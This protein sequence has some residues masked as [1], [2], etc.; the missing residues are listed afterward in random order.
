[1]LAFV[2]K[3]WLGLGVL[4]L[5]CVGF[6][7]A[8]AT[9]NY[10][11]KQPV[12]H[13]H[14]AEAISQDNRVPEEIRRAAATVAEA[15]RTLEQARTSFKTLLN[16]FRQQDPKPGWLN[17]FGPY[18]RFK[19]FKQYKIVVKRMDLGKEIGGLQPAIEDL[20]EA[21]DRFDEALT[22]EESRNPQLIQDINLEVDEMMNRWRE[23]AD[24]ANRQS[25]LWQ[26]FI[27]SIRGIFEGEKNQ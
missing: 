18:R 4:F 14:S 20:T 7:V 1:M 27:S 24:T 16:S 23:R 11:T 2:H 21:L 13:G 22:V 26:R 8:H 15:R 17:E 3:N 10:H 12:I 6:I 9:I 25:N 5:G 19:I